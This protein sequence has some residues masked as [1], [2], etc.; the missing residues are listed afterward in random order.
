[1]KF[2]EFWNRVLDIF[3]PPN[4]K[5][6][7]CG[8]DVPDFS[9]QPYCKECK[10]NQP[11]N[12]E[13]R[14]QICDMEIIGD[15]EI[16]ELC[17]ISH[18]EFNLVRSPMKYE[19]SARNV[20][21]KFKTQNARYLA[22]AMAKLMVSV[23][24]DEMKNADMIIP[25]PMTE[26]AIKKRGYNQS[27]LLANEISKLI[28]KPVCLDVLLKTK[29]THSQ[30]ELNFKERQKN[31]IGSFS[32]KN[33][34]LIKDKTILLVDDVM[35]TSATANVCSKELKRHARKVFVSVF[36]RNMINFDKK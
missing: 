12:T 8:R 15:G 30:K 11:F 23:M 26:K 22:F 1:M 5:C 36:A 13:H 34:R 16:C 21:L 14:C 6:I 10:E 2:K 27:I 31:L 32:I 18:K 19:G 25:V 17:K 29:E 20:V 28:N 9:N 4:L 24:T 3:F 35:T 33:Y 7:F